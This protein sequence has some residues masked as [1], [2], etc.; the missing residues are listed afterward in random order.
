MAAVSTQTLIHIGTEVV[1]IGGITFWF[2]KRTSDLQSQV[3]D[4]TKK[5][6]AALQVIDSQGKMLMAHEEFLRSAARPPQQRRV[7]PAP[8]TPNVPH[9]RRVPAEAHEVEPSKLDA[10]LQGELDNIEKQRRCDD[11]ECIVIDD[12]KPKKKPKKKNGRMTATE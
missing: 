1:I 9:A 6:E 10:I 2:A 5:L 4:L 11:D 3:D 7:E 12:P 8:P